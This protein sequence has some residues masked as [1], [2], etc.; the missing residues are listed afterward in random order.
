VEQIKALIFDLG[1]TLFKPP[2]IGA[3]YYAYHLTMIR[4]LLGEGFHFSE[5]EFKV[6]EG[7]AS[8]ELE[9]R[10]IEEAVGPHYE[11]TT[12]DWLQFDTAILRELGV[13]GDL[14]K[15]GREYQ[16][17]WEEF[18]ETNSPV[19]RPNA[20]EALEGLKGRGYKLGVATNWSDPSENLGKHGIL[21]LFQSIQYTLVPGYEKPSPYMLFMN[22]Q[23]LSVNPST[24]A[25]V[26]NSLTVDMG[27]ARRA[28]MLPILL[29]QEYHKQP[30]DDDVLVIENLAELLDIFE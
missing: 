23:S 30:I 18:I 10:L 2:E 17:L 25:F 16:R 13:K 8:G 5:Q 24:C 20:R 26:G 27:A 11:M 12:E 9:R 6:A 3:G 21:D 14:E 4:R 7:V 28:G 22:A 15:L 19:L 1:E 29:L